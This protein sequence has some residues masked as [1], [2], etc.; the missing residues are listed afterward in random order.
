MEVDFS[1]PASTANVETNPHQSKDS[2]VKELQDLVLTSPSN[3][4]VNIFLV[5][6]VLNFPSTMRTIEYFAPKEG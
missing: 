6:C 1:T 5:K 4:K 3:G 2:N